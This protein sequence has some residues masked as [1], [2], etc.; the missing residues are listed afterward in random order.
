MRHGKPVKRSKWAGDDALRP[1]VVKGE[2]QARGIRERLGKV[3]LGRIHASPNLRCRETVEPLANVRSQ[4]V[5]IDAR[6]S[7]D[8][9][10]EEALTLIDEERNGAPV[11]CASRSMLVDLLVALGVAQEDPASIRCQKGSLWILDRRHGALVDAEYVPPR[12]VPTAELDFERRSV[13]DLGSTSMS[14]L[15]ADVQRQEHRIE[16]VLRRR[17]ELRLGASAERI[18]PADASRVVRLASE[19]RDE[20]K[21]LGSVELL[22]VATASLRD[23][24]N[25]QAVSARLARVLDPPLRTLSG[26]EEARLVY[27]AARA[28]IDTTGERTL[29]FDLGGGSLDLAIGCDDR[30]DYDGSEPIGVTRL[31]AELVESDPMQHA[32]RERIRDR[33]RAR[34]EGHAQAIAEQPPT[35]CIAVGGT[36]RALARLARADEQAVAQE[37]LRA[38]EIS[39]SELAALT[40][41]LLHST[42]DE[43]LAMPTVAPRR[44]DLLPT[45]GLILTTLLEELGLHAMQVSDWGLREGVLLAG[46]D[47]IATV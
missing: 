9:D 44:A 11:L 37:G 39:L 34:L 16:P 20:A 35:R 41:R 25:G 33:V 8:A 29:A 12:E 23:A 21:S 40:A 46:S 22:S 19:M 4:S 5:E 45:G 17:V 32:D 6:L 47:A 10:V 2:N 30:I 15:V 31:H 38:L 27:R 43:R 13:L 24:A 3:P 7:E 36:A 42:H 26:A 1:L 14:L 18:G 28:R